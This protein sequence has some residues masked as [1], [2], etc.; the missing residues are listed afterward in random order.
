MRILRIL[1]MLRCYVDLSLK[2]KIT[3]DVISDYQKMSQS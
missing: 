3:K 1:R 2:D